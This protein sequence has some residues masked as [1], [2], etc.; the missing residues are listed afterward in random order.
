MAQISSLSNARIR[1][2]LA[3]MRSTRHRMR[4]GLMVIEG[5]RLLAEALRSSI[6]P[7]EI[8][9]TQAFVQAD[10]AGG[11]LLSQLNAGLDAEVKVFFVTE[12]VMRKMA[13]TVT[14]QGIIAVTP[15]PNLLPDT[16]VTPLWLIPDQ[17]RDPGNLGTI[18][19]TAWAAG[20]TE[21]L[22]PAGSV[23]YTQPKVVRAAMGAHYHLPIRQV[24]WDQIDEIIGGD[25][26]V[27]LA[28][29]HGEQPYDAVD[30]SKRS[31]LI[32]GGE[33]A[34]ASSDA[35]ARAHT[36]YIPMAPGVDSLNVAIATGILLF[37]ATR[38][39]RQHRV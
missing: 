10:R 23:D 38:Q 4:E 37:E 7:L 5:A 17:I 39:R 19:R 29:A 30:W 34:G 11:V 22:I 28:D 1:R 26:H 21:V 3:L 18:L 6:R 13:G 12:T 16:H 24:T 9:L 25:T 27:L 31:A 33:A 15:I 20:V 32:V 8:F 14:P 2:V 35:R 36:L